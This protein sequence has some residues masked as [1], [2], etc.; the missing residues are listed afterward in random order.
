MEISGQYCKNHKPQVCPCNDKNV[1]NDLCNTTRA[2]TVHQ[3]S[4]SGIFP[5]SS[6]SVRANFGSN[7]HEVTI[8]VPSKTP[9]Q[10]I[11]D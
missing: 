2:L 3:K 5:L 11:I 8:F 4:T 1:A 10:F 6:G 9:E 7:G